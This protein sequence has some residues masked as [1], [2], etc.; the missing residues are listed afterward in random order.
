[1]NRLAFF[2]ASALFFAGAMAG[3]VA[4]LR[5][6]DE[7]VQIE[8]FVRNYTGLL[9]EG[10]DFS[11]V[12]N[13]LDLTFSQKH[14]RFGFK[15]N[16]FAYQ[17]PTSGGDL[18]DF[19]ELYIDYYGD[20]L[21]LRL[22]KQQIVWGQADGVFITDIVSPLNLTEFLLWDFNEIRLGVTAL[23]ARYYLHDEHD[24]EF[25]WTPVF[26]P[27]VLPA[28]GSIWR[29][30]TSFIVTPTFDYSRSELEPSIKNSEFFFRYTLSKPS[31]D[32]QLIAASMWDDLASYHLRTIVDSTQ[33]LPDLI[34]TPEHHRLVMLGGNFSASL[35]EYV[36]RGEGAF[37]RGKQFQ[38]LDPLA[39]AALAERDYLNYVVGLD[40]AAGDWR[41]SA[42]Y[43]EKFIF[44]HD[45]LMQ[46]DEV[47]RMA[48]LMASRTLLREKAR[49]ELFSYVG[50]NNSDALIRLRGY[51]FPSDGVTL[52]L[53]GNAFLGETGTFGRFS[54]NNMI[55]TR[56]KFNF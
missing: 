28:E 4:E 56:I 44:D 9:L 38:T 2:A 10:G 48:T 25:V 17:Y 24:V 52:E 8:G 23:K 15:A 12:Q 14:D 31:L 7:G 27:S 47:D 49:V 54:D 6:Q 33:Y 16:A 32:V 45:D 53:G 19:R 1:M 22:G 42:Q 39:P 3:S 36:L 13:T 41:L 5:A 37:Y 21:D 20:K 29:P 55:Y 51:Y 26:T 30:A 11:I 50:L 34:V 46:E 40:R 18:Y 35:G 43:I